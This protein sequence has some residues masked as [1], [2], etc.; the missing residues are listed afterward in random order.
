VK[1]PVIVHDRRRDLEL[2]GVFD[3]VYARV[4]DFSIPPARG[5]A[6]R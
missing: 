4:E 5:A 1:L 3:E 2:R 6:R